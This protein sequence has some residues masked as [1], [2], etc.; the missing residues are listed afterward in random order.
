MKQYTPFLIIGFIL[1]IA[2]GDKLPGSLGKT[3]TQIRS[4]ANDFLVGL[5]PNGRPKTKPY[6]RTERQLEEMEKKR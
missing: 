5:F 4:G 3:S 2:V 1:Y 6:A